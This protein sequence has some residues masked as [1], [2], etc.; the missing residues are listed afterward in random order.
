MGRILANDGLAPAAIALLEEAGHE[1]V[2]DVVGPDALAA[3]ALRDYDGLIVRS[4]TKVTAEVIAATAGGRLEAVGRAGVGVDNIDLAAATEAGLLV[5]NAPFASTASVVELTI[6]HLLASVRHLPDADRSLRAGEWAKKRLTGTELGG[7]RLGFVGFGRIAQGVGEI[8]KALGMELWGY[9]P[10]LPP[11]V[12][13]AAGCVLVDDVDELFR[14]C[15]HIT[16]H[17]M[18]TDETRHLVGAER[19]A[20]MPGVSPDGIPCGNHVVNCARGGIVDEAAVLA[21]L[22][23][24]TLASCALDVFEQEPVAP[25]HPLLQHPRFHGTPHIGAGTKEA[26]H[27]VGLDTATAMIEAL[28]GRAPSTV[29]NRDVLLSWSAGE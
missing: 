3:G 19:I 6:G 4:A 11:A 28:A 5:F 17:A 20:L 14:Q 27:R 9:D 24:G 16:I 22:E 29:V 10:Y 2:L 26:Q 12:A 18:L 21:A 8:A 1:V 25:D 7:K 13:E 23:D 15:T